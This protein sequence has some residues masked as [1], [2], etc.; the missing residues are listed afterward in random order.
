ML[1]RLRRSHKVKHIS[2]GEDF[3]CDLRWFSKC[4]PKYNGVSMYAHQSSCDII[5]H[6]A[7]L[8]GIGG[9]L[10]NLVYHLPIP[11]GY[12]QLNIVHLEM[13]NIFLAVRLFAKVWSRL[14]ILIKCDN[15]AVVAVLRSGKT[16]DPF[17]GAC[18]RNI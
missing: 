11:V 5:E 7:C 3:K 13:V 17:L 12:K 1:E 2:L 18:A 16:K 10:K 15:A 6:D 4:L 9:Y 14:K 8:Q